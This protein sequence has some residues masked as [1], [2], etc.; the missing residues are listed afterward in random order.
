[1]AWIHPSVWKELA[2]VNCFILL[3]TQ[4]CVWHV[5]GISNAFQCVLLGQ[6]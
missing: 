1:M 6:S 3:F 2:T 4:M 5:L